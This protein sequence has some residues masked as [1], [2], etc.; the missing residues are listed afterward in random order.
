MGML[1][2]QSNHTTMKGPTAMCISNSDLM[3]QELL[4]ATSGGAVINVL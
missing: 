4:M 1:E 3:T 2:C